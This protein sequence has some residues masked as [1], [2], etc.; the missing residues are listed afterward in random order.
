L[1]IRSR[2]VKSERLRQVT[3]F[4]SYILL[5]DIAN[6]LNYSTD[7]MVI[8]ALIGPTSVAV[9]AVAQRLITATQDLTTQVSGALFPVVTDMAALGE[10]ARLREVFLQGTRL[11]FAMVIPVG[12]ILALL[13]SDVVW[14]WVGPGFSESVPVIW[15]LAVAVIIRVG[16]STATTILKGADEHS[17][18][19]KA[20]VA[21]AVVNLG[22]SIVLA[23][24]FG[25]IG[26]ALGTFVPLSII[27]ILLLFPRACRR[28]E[29][30]QIDAYRHGVW[31]SVWPI[32]PIVA[33]LWVIRS[34]LEPTLLNVAVQACVGGGAYMV[35]FLWLA[36]ERHE[37]DWYL[38]KIKN[39]AGW[40]VAAAE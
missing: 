10:T 15:I 21:M 6:K 34:Y 31:P 11:S 9:W 38:R 22:L 32:L 30:S 33:A 12:T 7:V 28:V 26:V 13:A 25:L 37:R 17:F 16:N 29:I 4:S 24:S 14:S 18:L 3:G 35:V 5:I 1:S 39:F 36:I 20:N 40:R 23:Q 19:T 2:H 27:S 8:G